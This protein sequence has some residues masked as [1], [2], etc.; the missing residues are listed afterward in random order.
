MPTIG[1][2]GGHAS[3]KLFCPGL[4]EAVLNQIEAAATA[5]QRRFGLSVD[6]LGKN[7]SSLF[8]SLNINEKQ[9]QMTA[10][11]AST[12]SPFASASGKLGQ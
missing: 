10:A 9:P 11:V 3:S 8:G 4:T 6:N 7:T 2:E 1:N 12:A 5:K